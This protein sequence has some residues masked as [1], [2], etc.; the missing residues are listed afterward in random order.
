[1]EPALTTCL[2]SCLPQT[3]V[4]FAYFQTSDAGDQPF[5]DGFPLPFFEQQ[6]VDG[7][8][9]PPVPNTNWTNNYYGGKNIQGT[10]IVYPNGSIDPWHALGIVANTTVPETEAIYISGTAHW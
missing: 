8:G 5:G 9:L 4:E 6:C 3:C 1:V 2:P 10:R 7:F